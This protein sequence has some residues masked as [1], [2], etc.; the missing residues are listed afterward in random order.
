M[1]P[2]PASYAP[3]C[4]PNLAGR[5]VLR[6]RFLWRR[7]RRAG[8]GLELPG[9]TCEREG[10]PQRG[11]N[12]PK[13]TIPVPL[14]ICHIWIRLHTKGACH[15]GR[16]AVGSTCPLS[17][18]CSPGGSSGHTSAAARLWL[19]SCGHQNSETIVEMRVASGPGLLTLI[20]SGQPVCIVSRCFCEELAYQVFPEELQQDLSGT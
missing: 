12:T 2:I 1:C 3:C 10:D 16:A 20:C 19:G 8:Q 18:G 14:S 17:A 15:E 7:P 9:T 13:P 4:L 6:T 5:C 11:P